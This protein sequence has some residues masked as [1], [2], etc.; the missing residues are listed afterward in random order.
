MDLETMI[1]WSSF[2]AYIISVILFM[3]VYN[4]R[5]RG[6]RFIRFNDGSICY[7]ALILVLM[8]MFIPLLNLLELQCGL[9]FFDSLEV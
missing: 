5:M 1:L 2:I 3:V 9:L 8:V 4:N 7:L 6:N